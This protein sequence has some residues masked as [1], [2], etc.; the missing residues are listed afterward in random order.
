MLRNRLEVACGEGFEIVKNCELDIIGY[1]LSI[2]Q[3]AR[4]QQGVGFAGM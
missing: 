1:S 2:T 4:M 3:L